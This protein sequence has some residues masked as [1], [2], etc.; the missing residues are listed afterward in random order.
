MKAQVPGLYA[1]DPARFLEDGGLTKVDTN[2]VTVILPGG[3][4]L[5]L[6]MDEKLGLKVS[7]SAGLVISP[8]AGNL[9]TIKVREP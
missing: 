9:V 7:G 2:Y 6:E 5:R 1:Y 3:G 8:R 4:S